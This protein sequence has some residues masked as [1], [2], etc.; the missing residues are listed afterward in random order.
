M[1]ASSRIVTA[2]L[3]RVSSGISAAISAGE[4]IA[5]MPA[6]GSQASLIIVVPTTVTSNGS[7]PTA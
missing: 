5:P 4:A 2:M 6:L 3:S 7:R 1:T